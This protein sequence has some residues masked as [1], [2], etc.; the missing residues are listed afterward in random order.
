M[1]LR[2]HSRTLIE[3]RLSPRPEFWE[4][5]DALPQREPIPNSGTMSAS[6]RCTYEGRPALAKVVSRTWSRHTADYLRWA[7]NTNILSTNIAEAIG[8]DLTPYL[9]Q[10][11]EYGLSTVLPLE[12]W[13]IA[14][15][16]QNVQATDRGVCAIVGHRSGLTVRQHIVANRTDQVIVLETLQIHTYLL[17]SAI[18]RAQELDHIQD[19]VIRFGFDPKPRNLIYGRIWTYVD[20]FP[21]LVPSLIRTY[22]NLAPEKAFQKRFDTRY[23]LYDVLMRYYR[24]CPE[25]LPELTATMCEVVSDLLRTSDYVPF[26]QDSVMAYHRKWGHL[27]PDA[28]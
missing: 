21:A 10:L 20:T 23:Y 16:F 22:R 17:G 7:Y 11:Q 19:H 25:W 14:D 6:Y 5:F 3:A 28:D 24:I 18:A 27:V 12:V 26:I 8:R 2:D 13:N 1:A 4:A 15:P 9:R